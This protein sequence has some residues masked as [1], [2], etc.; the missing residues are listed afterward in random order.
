MWRLPSPELVTAT[1]GIDPTNL[2]SWML[3]PP[4]QILGDVVQKP[5]SVN[6]YSRH[7]GLVGLGF[8]FTHTKGLAQNTNKKTIK[9]THN[10]K[11]QNTNKKIKRLCPLVI[12]MVQ[13]QRFGCCT[14]QRWAEVKLQTCK[15]KRKVAPSVF[16]FSCQVEVVTVESNTCVQ[17][18]SAPEMDTRA[19]WSQH[20]HWS[21]SQINIKV[22]IVLDQQTTTN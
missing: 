6:E 8:H 11:T 1:V 21:T 22:S 3:I 19:Q 20:K 2:E 14:R 12:V 9:K 5:Q 10:K 13:W 16:L 4:D 18:W 17:V 15:T 7:L